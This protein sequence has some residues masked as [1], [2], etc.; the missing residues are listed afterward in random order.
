ME[1]TERLKTE[2]DDVLLAEL[3]NTVVH[4]TL[5]GWVKK[6]MALIVANRFEIPIPEEWVTEFQIDSDEYELG[7]NKE[8]IMNKMTR[9]SFGAHTSNRTK[10]ELGVDEEDLQTEASEWM[11]AT[12]GASQGS[13]SSASGANRKKTY[14]PR[15]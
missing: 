9:S 8:L 15:R 3:L 2:S 13:S 14:V 11:H 6:E 5:T 7:K 4:S 12:V 1:K 10:E